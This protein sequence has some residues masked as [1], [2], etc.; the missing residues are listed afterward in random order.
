MKAASFVLY[1]AVLAAGAAS[2]ADTAGFAF[3]RIPV[4]AR[5]AAMGGAFCAVPGVPTSLYW[6][7]ASAVSVSSQTITTHYTGYFLDM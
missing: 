7:P 2:A 6:N 5:A 3:L 4:G 1:T